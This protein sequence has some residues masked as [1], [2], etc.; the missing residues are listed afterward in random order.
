MKKEDK[1]LH[2]IGY[3][4]IDYDKFINWYNSDESF[5]WV[6]GRWK[7]HFYELQGSGLDASRI[8]DNIC[9]CTYNLEDYTPNESGMKELKYKFSCAR[10]RYSKWLRDRLDYAEMFEQKISVIYE[11]D[12]MYVILFGDTQAVIPK[13]SNC[14][15]FKPLV[16]Y[17][18]QQYINIKNFKK[19]SE[20]NSEINENGLIDQNTSLVD[21]QTGLQKISEFEKAFKDRKKDIEDGKTKELEALQ[22]EIEDKMAILNKRKEAL[23][24][25]LEAKKEELEIMKQQL[26]Q[27]MFI[28]ETEIY[29]IRCYLGEVVDFIHLRK[30]KNADLEQPLVM[31]QKLRYLD[32]ELGKLDALYNFSI[33]DLK[34]FEQLVQR[35]DNIVNNFLPT[36]KCVC[37]VRLSKT[38]IRLSSSDTFANVLDVYKDEHG[39][40]IGILIRDGENVYMTWTDEDKIE[41][42]EDMFYRPGIKTY[43][44]EDSDLIEK[45]QSTKE[46]IASRYFLFNIL[47]GAS[48][49]EY[50]EPILTL[51]P[52]A[53]LYIPSEY[54]IYSTADAW[55][56]DNRFGVLSDIV[57]RVNECTKV[58]DNVITC[59]SLFPESYSGKYHTGRWENVRGRGDRNITHDVSAH[60]GQIY[61]INCIDYC[62]SS[63]EITTDK[64][65]KEKHSRW[66]AGEIEEWYTDEVKECRFY[67]TNNDTFETVEAK[68]DKWLEREGITRENITDRKEY[69][70]KRTY[71]SLSKSNMDYIYNGGR[72]TERQREARANFSIYSDEYVNVELM[73]SEWI[74]YFLTTRKIGKCFGSLRFADFNYV[75]F[76]LNKMLKLVVEREKEEYELISQYVDLTKYPEWMVSLSEWKISTGHHKIGTR[77]AKQFAK[78][79]N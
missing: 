24:A 3:A 17:S 57:E 31:L 59:Q 54:V 1:V 29:A 63:I 46:E 33:D 10:T 56:E 9:G 37:L 79:L 77:Y 28:L 7:N 5:D 78:T 40:K 58:G 35:D 6:N 45:T 71:I 20:Y 66:V 4:I 18:S 55:L 67:F 42:K 70:T 75:V 11:D 23:M 47:L 52:K 34:Y 64:A 53:N 21:M 73:N 43:S 26:E 65:Y 14:L 41:I 61:P 36:Q 76:Y 2:T 49:G 39:S 60:D 27:K 74:K 62:D 38:G 19:L 68:I 16:D 13:D 44:V 48:S 50:T 22:K 8:Y 69:I 30:G 25:E 32:E 12:Q 72:Y 15:T 51:N